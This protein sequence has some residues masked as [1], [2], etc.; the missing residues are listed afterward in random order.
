MAYL[1]KEIKFDFINPSEQLKLGMS[2][3][4]AEI[5]LL[6]NPEVKTMAENGQL[7]DL[8]ERFQKIEA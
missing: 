6:A 2:I 1:N 4:E 8:H 3:K 5:L 7:K